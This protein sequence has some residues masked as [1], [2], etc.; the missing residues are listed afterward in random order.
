MLNKNSFG[1]YLDSTVGHPGWSGG[2][3]HSDTSL[4]ADGMD[5]MAAYQGKGIDT[6]QIL[7]LA[8]GLWDTSE[9]VLAFEDLHSMHWGNG[10]G[11]N[12]GFPEWSDTEPDFTDFVV[13]VESVSPVPEPATMLLLGTGLI[14]IAG[15][16]R[17]KFRKS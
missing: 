4:N 2:I 14:G 10:N 3:W 17:R 12:D 7:P 16:S 1:Y 5:H 6:I 15:F 8:P 13:M 9:Y 11:I